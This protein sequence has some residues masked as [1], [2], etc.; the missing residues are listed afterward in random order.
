MISIR[1]WMSGEDMRVPKEGSP[2]AGA[3][4]LVQGN[5]PFLSTASG[6]RSRAR[7]Q[8]RRGATQGSSRVDFAD[9]RSEPVVVGSGSLRATSAA[10]RDSPLKSNGLSE[11][12]RVAR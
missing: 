6:D 1:R 4:D 3:A 12:E 2:I 7:A 5:A 10:R 11:K 8:D 9:C